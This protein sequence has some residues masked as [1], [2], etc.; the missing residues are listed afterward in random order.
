MSGMEINVLL[1]DDRPENLLALES[2]LE[3]DSSYSIVKCTSGND[4]LSRSLEYEFAVVLMDVQMPEMDGFETAKLM[5]GNARTRHIPIIF[6]TANSKEQSQIFEGYE[7]GAVDY[8]FK[9]FEPEI[10][11]SKVAVFAELYR[12][13]RQVESA[14]Q[15]ANQALADLERS[16]AELLKAIHAA[17]EATLTKSR[18]LAN[19]SH[20]IRTPINGVI[21]MTQLLL[22]TELTSEQ[23]EYAS[24]IDSSANALM[25]LI[26]DIL[27]FSKVEAGKL[28]I[29]VIDFDL[30]STLEEMNDSLAFRAYEKGLEYH[31]LIDPGTPTHL[32]GDPGRIRQVLTNLIG[33]A[34]KFT[35]EG[36]INL[37]V[38]LEQEDAERAVI[39]IEVSDT[40]IGIP[41]DRLDFLFEA[42]TQAD[43]STTRKYGG[44]GLGL[45][46][47][48]QIVELMG[49]ELHAESEE[50]KGSTFWFTFNVGKSAGEAET[51]GVSLNGFGS[52]LK[53][54]NIL[55]VDDNETNRLVFRRQLESWGCNI[56]EAPDAGSGF[57]LLCAAA[58]DGTPIDVALIDMR[59]PDINGDELGKKIKAD[60][61][62]RDVPLVMMTS[63]GNRGD[64]KRL[65]DIG[66]SAY[67]TKPLKQSQLHECLTTIIDSPAG[68]QDGKDKPLITRHTLSEASRISCCVLLAEDN[69][70]NQIVGTK[71][72]EKMGCQVTVANNGAEA[73]E[74]LREDSFDIV[75]M[76]IQMPQLDGIE[77]TRKIRLPETGAVN[78]ATPIVAMTAHVMKGDKDRCLEAGMDGYI[79]KPISPAKVAEALDIHV[80]KKS[81]RIP[82]PPGPQDTQIRRT[83]DTASLLDAFDGD[84]EICREVLDVFLESTPPQLE[85]LGEAIAQGE[86]EAVKDHLHALRGSAASVRAG[87]MRDRL[88]R[89]EECV[90]RNGLDDA[91]SMFEDI[92]RDFEKVRTVAAL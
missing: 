6:V 41:T 31:C 17:E 36:E 21:G 14:R 92:E 48:K 32:Q 67:L 90:E 91:A 9:P 30:R 86:V 58:S 29:E 54:K 23:Q 65:K 47:S 88:G 26:N 64:A 39:R 44:T 46:I 5:R 57:D 63:I 52:A 8:I 61:S 33:N 60:S 66:F 18:F 68:D 73:V 22:E 19:M 55:V 43:A 76:D 25:T 7:A 71:I 11:K 82:A 16:R 70:T 13:K 79:S 34:V 24:C 4:A 59:L 72:L 2:V 83:L 1:V 37:N 15:S 69:K 50:G 89:L 38:S 45:T 27:D 12:Q 56:S 51:A 80:A 78:P 87:V 49:G 3:E 75:F 77:A 74:K 35:S 28:D 62:L 85:Q 20:E 81:R 10:V 53:D 84:K 40:G 42:F